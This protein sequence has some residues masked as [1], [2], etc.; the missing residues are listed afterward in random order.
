MLFFEGG[1]AENPHYGCY[2]RDVD[3]G[4]AVRLGDGNA[5]GI[6]PDGQWVLAVLNLPAGELVFHPT[7]FGET[8]ALRLEGVEQ[9]AWVGFHPDGTRLLGVPLSPDGDTAVVRRHTGE[10]VLVS[11]STREVRPVPGLAAGDVVLRFA[12]GGDA[13]LVRRG[14]VERQVDRL[15]LATG[16]RSP[17]RTLAPPDPTGILYIGSPVFAP[18]GVRYGYSYIRH[19]SELYLVEGLAQERHTQE[20]PLTR[21]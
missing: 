12:P 4:P 9:V 10:H 5:M 16:V 14:E 3:G 20:R 1:E 8:R 7:G 6:S 21:A 11:L 17:W 13:L 15:E 18:S 2:L 19:E